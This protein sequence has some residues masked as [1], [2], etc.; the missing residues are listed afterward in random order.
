MNTKLNEDSLFEALGWCGCSDSA[1]TEAFQS[2]LDLLLLGG[3]DCYFTDLALKTSLDQRLV[4]IILHE[5]TRLDLLE[6]G[7]SVRGSWFKGDAEAERRLAVL[8]SPPVEENV[9]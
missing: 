4:Q 7:T 6:H 1:I 2:I 9:S 5:L 8:C 3:P